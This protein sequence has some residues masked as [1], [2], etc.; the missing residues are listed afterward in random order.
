M[1]STLVQCAKVWTSL[2]ALIC[3]SEKLENTIGKINLLMGRCVNL[4]V[5]VSFI[6][7]FFYLFF[8]YLFI[9]KHD[10]CFFYVKNR[11]SPNNTVI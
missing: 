6:L 1:F 2:D 4:S 7:I 8:I 10:Q 5:I 3:V 9:Q 11:K